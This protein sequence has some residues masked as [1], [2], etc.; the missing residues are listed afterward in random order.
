MKIKE[1]ITNF[2]R[3]LANPVGIYTHFPYVIEVKVGNISL[4]RIFLT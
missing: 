1:E 4:M 3:E 2:S